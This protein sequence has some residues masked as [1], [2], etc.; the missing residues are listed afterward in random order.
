MAVIQRVVAP[1]PGNGPGT[2]SRPQQDSQPQGI[3]HPP[4]QAEH[5][6]ELLRFQELCL[7]HSFLCSDARPPLLP[8]TAGPGGL[9]WERALFLKKTAEA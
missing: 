2:L 1:R 7:C 6:Q 8:R 3:P 9:A 5:L 4:H